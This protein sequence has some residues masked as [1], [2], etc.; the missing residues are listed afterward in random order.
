MTTSSEIVNRVANRL[1]G[2][3]SIEQI[4]NVKSNLYIV[5]SDYD[6]NEKTTALAISEDDKKQ[7][8]IQ[9]FFVSKKMEGC[10]DKTLTYY[11]TI[12]KKFF[13]VIT[14]QLDEITADD[15]RFYL[16][17]MSM[18]KRLSKV[19]QDNEL[20]VL[21]SFFKWCFGEGY[22]S[23]IPT[24]NIK[25]IK[26]EKRIKKAFTE[27]QVELLRQSAQKVKNNSPTEKMKAA[28]NIAMIDML[29]STGVRVSELVGMNISDIQNDEI[30][31]FGKG[32]KERTVYLNAKAKLS[33][34]QYL[35]LRNYSEDALFTSTKSPYTR[36]KA[37]SV[38]TII[39]EIGEKAGVKNTHPH[40]FRRTAAT[41]ALNRGMPIEQVSQMLGHENIE[42]TTIYAR[43]DKE[44]V[45]A[46][47]KK[48]VV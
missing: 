20:R 31:V 7:K 30:I 34:E 1:D 5:L 15:I 35:A 8:A 39:R 23:K 38:E 14:V 33:I 2:L 3:M 36:L 40:R 29:F 42:T 18:E 44:N 19:S 4:D 12:L 10:T 32:E 27:T 28:R 21:K 6:F 24:L 45:K 25:S 47:H 17:K 16:A 22:I 13:S 9:M 48:Y 46:S 43:S 26:Q 37:G 11:A 41:L